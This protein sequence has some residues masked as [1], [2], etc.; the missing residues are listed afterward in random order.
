MTMTICDT[1]APVAIAPDEPA[2]LTELVRGHAG[3][4]S[5]SISTPSSASTQP[6]LQ[7]W[8]RF[9]PPPAQQATASP[10]RKPRRG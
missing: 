4:P 8:L 1:T 7:P 9:T 3:N 2:E 6:A 5:R 10:S